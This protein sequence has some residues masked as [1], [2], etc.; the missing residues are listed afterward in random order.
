MADLKAVR[1]DV[2]VMAE[3]LF[4]V[5]AL[6]FAETTERERQVIAAFAFGMVFAEGQRRQLTP[7]ETHAVAIG[8][9]MDVFK[10]ADHQ[11]ADFSADLIAT[12]SNPSRH[13]VTNA[14]IHRGID[15]H[16]QWERDDIDALTSNVADVLARVQGGQ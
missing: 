5:L 15:G 16:M 4:D 2:R 6:P 1:Q 12:A 7:P 3:S 9:L 14:I 11:A 10:Y 8:L 13:K